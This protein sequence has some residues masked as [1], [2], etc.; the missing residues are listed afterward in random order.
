MEEVGR[1]DDPDAIHRWNILKREEIEK[2]SY[3]KKTFQPDGREAR[4]S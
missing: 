4:T 3:Y 1:C 2:P